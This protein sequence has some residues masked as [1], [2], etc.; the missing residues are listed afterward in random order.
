MAYVQEFE[1]ARST[2]LSAS[3]SLG[4]G[5]H[6]AGH[7]CGRESRKFGDVIHLQDFVKFRSCGG[8]GESPSTSAC[9][10]GG[11]NRETGAGAQAFCSA[12]STRY[13]A[14]FPIGRGREPTA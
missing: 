12:I 9:S 11:A 8:N 2:L 5:P 10:R 3:G 1:K 7:G 14:F 13:C 6:R 4:N